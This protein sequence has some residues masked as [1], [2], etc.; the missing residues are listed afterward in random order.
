MNNTIKYFRKYQKY[1][2]G[3]NFIKSNQFSSFKVKTLL[4]TLSYRQ[5]GQIQ[6]GRWGM[7]AQS[8]NR[9][10]KN[11]DHYL[12]EI[13]KYARY[14]G[15][16]NMQIAAMIAN[17]IHENQGSPLAAGSRVGLWQNDARQ[18]KYMGTTV[19]SNVAAFKKDYDYGK[20]YNTYDKNG[21]DPAYHKYFKNGKNIDDVTY[22]MVAGY[23]RFNGSKNR[24]NSEVRARQR[25]A[26]VV[27]D[28]LQQGVKPSAMSDILQDNSLNNNFNEFNNDN[29]I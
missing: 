8:T 4:D 18:A 27:Y 23:E 5:G 26:K 3:G 24:N 2:K 6:K 14:H 10:N 22:G 21:W 9:Y 17:A 29:L 16:N 25:T 13:E 7:I 28:L 1:K 12:D 11:N 15:F 20:W 19:Q